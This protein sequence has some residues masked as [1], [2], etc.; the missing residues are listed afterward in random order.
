MA[1]V[2]TTAVDSLMPPPVEAGPAP[3]NI[4]TITTSSAGAVSAATSMVLKPAVRVDI[5][6]NSASTIRAVDGRSPSV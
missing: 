1:A 6:R 4:S 5:D 2:S 3:M